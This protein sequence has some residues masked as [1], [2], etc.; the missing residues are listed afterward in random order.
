MR[1]DCTI[2]RTVLLAGALLAL[3]GC[4]KKKEE[5]PQLGPKCTKAHAC[6]TALAA[7]VPEVGG[8]CDKVKQATAEVSCDNRMKEA[9]EFASIKG[10][11]IPAACN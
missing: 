7:A 8:I 10:A 9:K 3:S 4:S 5:A 11:A 1:L 2:L 6:C